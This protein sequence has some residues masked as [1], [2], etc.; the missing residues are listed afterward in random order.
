MTYRSLLVTR[1]SRRDRLAVLVVA[2]AVALLVGATLLAVTAGEQTQTLAADFEANATV[3]GYDSLEAA[4]DD[5][6]PNAT[7]LPLAEATAPDG[8]SHTAVGIP[9]ADAAGAALPAQ[10]DGAVGPVSADEEWRLEGTAESTTQT[11]SPGV[12]SGSVP[13]TWVRTTPEAVEAVGPTGAL[14]LEPADGGAVGETGSPLVGALAFFAGGTRSVIGLLWVGVAVAGVVV[15]VTISSVVR[16]TVS[17]RARTIRVIRAT[18]APPRR[19]RLLFALRGGAL[20]GGGVGLGYALGVVVPN[21]AVNVAIVAGLPT[22]LSIRVTREVAPLLAGMLA[23]LVLVGAVGGYLA[24]RGATTVPP[25]RVGRPRSATGGGSGR[26]GRVRALLAPSLLEARTVVPTA[27]TLSVFAVIVLLI[28]SLAAVGAALTT[29]EATITEPGSPHP[30]ESSVPESYAGAVDND[31]AAS[32]EI[33]LFTG[34]DGEPYLA[35]GVDYEA[36][37]AVT[38]A[39]VVDGQPPENRSEA[40]IGTALADALDFE[41]GDELVVGGSTDAA[42]AT[43][44]IAG[45]YETGTL[46]DHQLLVSLP[47]ARH[48][49]TVDP[50]DVNLVRTNATAPDGAVGPTSAVLVEA[51][52]PGHAEPGEPIP[53]SVTLWNP[54]DEPAE[55]TVEASIGDETVERTVTVDPGARTTETIELPAV[56]AGE[57][58]VRV[59]SFE[60]TTTVAT[61]PPL[62]FAT[63]A[64]TAPPGETTLAT[65]VDATGD[66]VANAT[67]EAGE[68]TVT[69]DSEGSAWLSLP[70]ESGTVDVTA[71]TDERA[72]T[73]SVTISADA[74]T[75]LLAETG[76][77][78]ATPGI[79]SRPTLEVSLSNPW[80]RPIETTV[81]IDGPG[82]SASE[83]VTLEAGETTTVTTTFPQRPPGEYGVAVRADGSTLATHEYRVGGDDRL[84]GALAAS[85][86]YDGGGGI[87]TAVEYAVGNLHVLLGALAGLASLTVVGATSAVLTRAVRARR[88]SLGIYRATGASPRRLLGLVLADAVRIGVAA[89]LLALVVAT[90]TLEA[91][92]LAGRLTVFGITLDPRP[93]P[94][95]AAGIVVVGV[96]LTALSALVATRSLVRAS[97]A[98]LFAPPEPRGGDAPSNREPAP[99]ADGGAPVGERDLTSGRN[100]GRT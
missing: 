66:P 80:Q 32:P 87:A 46:E 58:E 50:G 18:G 90:A 6:G 89:S 65:L 4:H 52:A 14:A 47:T 76:L 23:G 63:L 64:G 28:G 19:I 5:T 56:E 41:P 97:P 57:Y 75:A 20:A 29:D 37:A 39:T 17:E 34:H 55:R 8:T 73:E 69:T 99:R 86:H 38:N 25:A 13:D 33:V 3:T 44:E 81:E 35:R 68:E 95:L 96:L 72:V 62:E 21:V 54:A 59:G 12:S 71:R 93:A 30:I 83:D 26:L 67:I 84:T 16:T 70:E 77:E 98:S 51:E 9:A 1:W 60:R 100:N 24:A 78:P 42:F 11:V 27:A 91:L 22:T 7:V 53:A 31:T 43:V 40:A 94:A 45:V 88:R 79:H 2:L 74:E 85:G 36:F 48:L 10:P 49:S 82:T 92:A 61:E 15:A